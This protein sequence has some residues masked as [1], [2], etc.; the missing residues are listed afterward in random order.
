M[1]GKSVPVYSDISLQVNLIQK[2]ATK[3]TL[4][5][6]LAADEAFIV[7]VTKLTIMLI[8]QS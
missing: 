8:R 7:E 4:Q 5:V 1:A 6:C 3:Y 2:L